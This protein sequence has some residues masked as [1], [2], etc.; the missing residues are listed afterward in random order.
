MDRAPKF[1]FNPLAFGYPPDA[2]WQ[3]PTVELEQLLETSLRLELDAEVTPIQIW[4]LVRQNPKFD[5]FT[6]EHLDL[7]QTRLSTFVKCYGFVF[8]S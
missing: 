3:T 1:S 8:E 2:K 5:A 6:T 4:N 7:L